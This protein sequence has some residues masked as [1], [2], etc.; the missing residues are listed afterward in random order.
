MQS[1]KGAKQSGSFEVIKK[2]GE[3]KFMNIP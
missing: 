2:E 3:K 1:I